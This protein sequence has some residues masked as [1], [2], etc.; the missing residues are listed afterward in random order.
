[1]FANQVIGFV[2]LQFLLFQTFIKLKPT[3]SFF[4]RAFPSPPAIFT[5]VIVHSVRSL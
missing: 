5:L 2:E 4:A 3:V 1:M